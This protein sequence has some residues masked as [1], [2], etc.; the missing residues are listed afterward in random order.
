MAQQLQY[1][2]RAE[3]LFANLLDTLFLLLP[4]IFLFN[5]FGEGKALIA[6]FVIYAAYY[7]YFVGS[8]WQATPGKRVLNIHV[9]MASG[10]KPSHAAAFERFIVYV[11]PSLPLYLSVL[12]EE[13]AKLLF[14]WLN[15]LWFT[16]I[17]YTPERRG[18]HDTIVGTRVVAGKAGM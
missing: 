14:L 10:E 1:A 16:P 3:R 11:L 6:G 5:V 9:V 15:L 17:L 2:G 8:R 13:S 12:P 7:T 18:L 4:N